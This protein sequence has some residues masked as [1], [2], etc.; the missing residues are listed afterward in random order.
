[1][2]GKF[3][4]KQMWAMVKWLAGAMQEKCGECKSALRA[5]IPWLVSLDA[6]SAKCE[7]MSTFYQ[8][9]VWY[10]IRPAYSLVDV[11]IP[12]RKF[13][14]EK[15]SYLVRGSLRKLPVTLL[16]L[17]VAGFNVPFNVI[18]THNKR[19][20]MRSVTKAR[21]ILLLMMEMRSFQDSSQD[22][23]LTPYH[24]LAKELEETSQTDNRNHP[25]Q[26]S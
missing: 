18:Y 1:M 5:W 21:L 10:V 20:A 17:L 6:I 16:D 7:S 26:G 3:S 9:R 8:Q 24:F 23:S 13:S 15:L 4:W 19:K 12:W 14:K 25:I 11:N 22:K 2:T